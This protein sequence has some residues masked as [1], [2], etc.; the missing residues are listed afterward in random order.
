[1]RRYYFVKVIN[2]GEKF[3]HLKIQNFFLMVFTLISNHI[4][5]FE[6]HLVNEIKT[7]LKIVDFL[8]KYKTLRF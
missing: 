7:Y 1:M 4:L 3:L 8:S 5:N 2:F 6:Q